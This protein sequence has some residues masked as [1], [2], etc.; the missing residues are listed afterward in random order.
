MCTRERGSL[1]FEAYG[2]G[3]FTRATVA[4]LGVC[5]AKCS[6]GENLAISPSA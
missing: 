5:I 1:W 3:A 6:L 2:S 4:L